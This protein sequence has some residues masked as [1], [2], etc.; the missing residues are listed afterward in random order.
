[1]KLSRCF[2]I[3]SH[4]IRISSHLILP[5]LYNSQMSNT[6][7]DILQS[8][9]RLPI[10]KPGSRLELARSL[11]EPQNRH[12]L[13]EKI[14]E[15]PNFEAFFGYYHSQCVS[16]ICDQPSQQDKTHRQ[17]V[18]KARE[19]SD[20]NAQQPLL[21]LRTEAE[22]SWI[23]LVVRVLTMI[24]VGGLRN[25]M[26]LGQDSRHWT[27]GSLKDFIAST[28]PKQTQLSNDVKLERMFTA[29]NLECVTD[30]Q[31]IWT[32]NLADH[33]QLEEEDTKVRVF[34]HSSFLEFHRDCDLFP[35]GFVEE[36][37]RTLSLLLPQNDKKSKA[38]FQGE[39]KRDINEEFIDS[40]AI[41]CRTLTMKERRIDNFEFW[42][43]RLVTLKQAFD[44]ADPRTV[45]QFWFDRRKP[46]QWFNFWIAI[47]LVVF[48][49]FFFG[50]IQ[51]VGVGLQVY[52]AYYP[53][54][55]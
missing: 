45:R 28:F 43:D 44:Q 8:A 55:A 33:L 47:A 38:W 51:S 27:H 36:T 11:W 14:F 40:K 23:F 12:S 32:S 6:S 13:V 24:D 7:P 1:M 25:G 15:P 39:L 5:R 20:P 22:L 52:K 49:T 9:L 3:N 17:L 29:R 41:K 19:I 53:S 42:H 48:L 50:V 31:I 37:L 30:I 46:A 4:K 18:D 21:P 34:S 2:I 26:R 35:T 16:W 54:S 10:Q